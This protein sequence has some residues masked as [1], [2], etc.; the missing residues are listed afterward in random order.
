MLSRR[1]RPL[2]SRPRPGSR[3]TLSRKLKTKAVLGITSLLYLLCV[4]T[5]AYCGVLPAVVSDVLSFL[6]FPLT[7]FNGCFYFALGKYIVENEQ[8]ILKKANQKRA[9]IGMIVFFVIFI[10]EIILT[11][12]L[13]ILDSTDVAFTTAAVSLFL[14]LFL[15]Q[16]AVKVKN[17][18]LLRKFSTIIYCCQGNVLLVNGFLKK[19]FNV[20]SILAFL[21][22]SLVVAAICLVVIFLQKRTKWTWTKYLT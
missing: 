8:A 13:N 7:I 6:C 4:L 16:S 1:P 3:R 14:F 12:R 19:I 5:S 18:L 17:A 2:R 10:L 21:L 9:L 20:P 11:T 15:L 22:S